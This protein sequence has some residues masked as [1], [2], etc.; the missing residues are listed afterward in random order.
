MSKEHKKLII[1]AVLVLIALGSMGYFCYDATEQRAVTQNK[2]LAEEAL[3]ANI[4]ADI[5][6][7]PRLESEIGKLKSKISS[8]ERTLPSAKEAEDTLKL[9]Q[10]LLVQTN[11]SI[12]NLSTTGA[13][14]RGRRTTRATGPYKRH[15]FK[16]TLNGTYHQI[17][18]FISGLEHLERF[19]SIESLSLK[20]GTKK[21]LNVAMTVVTYSFKGGKK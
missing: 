19:T 17:S 20:G 13:A 15:E 14:P 18:R 4:K 3:L 12:K 16:L 8:Y 10:V 7:I 6:K 2:L 11:I 9:L 21:G 5:R 1:T